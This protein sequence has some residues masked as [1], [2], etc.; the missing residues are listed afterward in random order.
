MK[1]IL[2]SNN[3]KT[4]LK[5]NKNTPRIA[6]SLYLHIDNAEKSAGIYTLLNRL[7]LQGTKKRSAEDLAVEL[8]ENGI[9]C[10]SEMKHDFIRFK[11]FCLNEDFEKG[12]EILSDIL[13]NST[14]ENF[15]KEK[16]KLKGEIVSD[17]DSP[18]TKAT[19]VFYST[20]YNGFSYSNTCTKILENIDNITKQDVIDA[21]DDIFNNSRKIITLVGDFEENSVVDLL[22]KNFNDLKTKENEKICAKADLQDI[23]VVKIP[24]SD[25]KQAQILQGWM[26][27]TM[28]SEDYFAISLLNTILGSSGL[29][30]R[31]FLELRDKKGLAYTVRSSYDSY[32]KASNFHVYIGTD[33]KNIET[34]LEGFKI[35]IDK[36]KNELISDE[37]LQDAKNNIIGKR[38]F[39]N[40]TNLLQANFFGFYE[41][42]CLGYDFEK[43]FIEN[44]K[45]VTAQDIM[46]VANKYLN[47]KYVLVILA[48]EKYLNTQV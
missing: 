5:I 13:K 11:L 40:E 23:K 3:L 9:E 10:Y 44:I 14:F 17:L 18:K 39:Y 4:I 47:D 20:I 46:N 41:N 21:F 27:P 12:L 28:T 35:E 42:F 36:V 30:S 29:S 1:D 22:E 2:L 33:P 38:N 6:L 16:V 32:E 25:A 45:K 8:E 26:T 48:P 43:R 37:E 15:E 34:A 19:D 31:L 7:F 24:K